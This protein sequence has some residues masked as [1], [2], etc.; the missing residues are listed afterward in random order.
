MTVLDHI[1]NG[2][3]A[4][5]ELERELGVRTVEIDRALLAGGL[6]SDRVGIGSD[7]VGVGSD[8]VGIGS[9]RVGIG[10]DRVGIGSD[11]VNREPRFSRNNR[12]T[13]KTLSDS[14][15]TLTDAKPTLKDP[16]SALSDPNRPGQYDFIFLHEKQLSPG[17][18]E[19]ISK[20]VAAMKKTPETAPV[21]FDGTLPAAKIYIVLG[22]EALKKWFPGV[23][24]AP[25]QWRKGRMG[26]DILVSYSPDFI[27][28]F[29]RP[30][31]PDSKSTVD[32]KRELWTSL[33]GVMQRI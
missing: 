32:M 28:R 3:E 13:L 27:L 15:P 25:G 5:L 22:R 20:A 17:G 31:V 6:E 24:A 12:T 1:L 23:H 30:G 14:N 29:S 2:F 8:R 9:D 18:A 11:K 7:R 33:K 10:S 16:K 26:E 4:E 21:V 19:M